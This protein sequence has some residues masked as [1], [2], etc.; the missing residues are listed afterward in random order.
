MVLVGGGVRGWEE[1]EAGK[2]KKEPEPEAE[3][4]R[5]DKARKAALA[6]KEPTSRAGRSGT[7]GMDQR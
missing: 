7:R 4:L 2:L 3:W 1:A 5:S 6:S